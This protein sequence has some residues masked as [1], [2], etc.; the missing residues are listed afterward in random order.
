MDSSD[1][2]DDQGPTAGADDLEGERELQRREKAERQAKKRKANDPVPDIFK[3]R[4]K[5]D[6]MVSRAA[7]PPRPKKKSERASWIPTAEDAPTRASARGTTRQSKEQLHEQM[8][9]REVKRIKQLENMEKAAAAKEAKKKPALTQADRLAEAARAEK[10]NSKS[11]SRWEEAEQVREEERKAKL[12]ALKDRHMDGPYIT[13]WSGMAEWIGGKLRQVGKS[14]MVEEKEKPAVGRKRKH[15]EMEA[16]EETASVVGGK[17]LEGGQ[18]SGTKL[19]E[20]PTPVV[21][22]VVGEASGEPS[23]DASKPDGIAEATTSNEDAAKPDAVAEA[24]ASNEDAVT[25]ARKSDAATNLSPAPEPT[26][27]RSE[28]PSLPVFFG[29]HESTAPRSSVLAPPPGL[30][31]YGPPPPPR[32]SIAHTPSYP[33][34]NAP[35]A[36]DGSAPLPGFGFNFQQP[37]LTPVPAAPP[38]PSP[39]PAEPPGPPPIEHA[40]RNYLILANFDETL[41]KD[42]NVQT[43]ILFNRKFVK[44]P[45]KFSPLF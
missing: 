26:P 44:V 38:Q 21:S 39:P 42:K 34:F 43:Q 22:L 2:D 4:V 31:L 20:I 33:P 3:K 6:P 25:S 41:V 23:P 28:Q 32:G 27:L 15:A 40:A 37:H 7:P 10:A 14:L 11:L 12:A 19:E 29:P 13:W 24:T 8:I 17:E 30:P 16:G 45:R 18:A 1:D 35:P 5:I 9:L 36:L